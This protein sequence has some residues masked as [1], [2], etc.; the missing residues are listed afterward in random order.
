[1]LFRWTFTINPQTHKDVYLLH[2]VTQTIVKKNI[3]FCLARRTSAIA[4]KN[5]E[6][7]RNL[8]NLKL[9]LSKYHYPD[10]LIK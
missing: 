5:A 7:L 2:P 8:E 4:E 6:K 1:M 9:N 3:P 10:S